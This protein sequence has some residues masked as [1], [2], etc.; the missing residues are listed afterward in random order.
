[1]SFTQELLVETKT[2]ANDI[3]KTWRSAVIEAFS[4]VILKTPVREGTARGSWMVGMSVGTELGEPDKSGNSTV[5]RAIRGVPP[6]GN[7][8]YLYS[9]LPYIVP[10]EEGHSRAQ[11]PQGMVN[12]VVADWPRIVKKHE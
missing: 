3:D 2:M 7:S 9:N 5:R 1:M 8:V 10:L 11:A 6:V 12:L 4:R